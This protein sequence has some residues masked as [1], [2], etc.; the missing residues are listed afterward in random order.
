MRGR[1]GHGAEPHRA[2]GAWSGE[3]ARLFEG[4]ARGRSGRFRRGLRGDGRR[5]RA[6]RFPQL[7]LRLRFLSLLFLRLLFRL[8]LFLRLL[9]LYFLFFLRLPHSR[10]HRLRRLGVR[11]CLLRLGFLGFLGRDFRLFRLRLFCLRLALQPLR[12]SLRALRFLRDARAFLFRPNRNPRVPNR[13]R[14]PESSSRVWVAHPLPR[15]GDGFLH[16]IFLLPPQRVRPA[17]IRRA[18]HENLTHLLHAMAGPGVHVEAVHC[19][20]PQTGAVDVIQ[21]V[22]IREALL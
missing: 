1:D 17:V 22:I 15:R 16:R 10:H 13:R 12:L 8:R 18:H 5:V 2:L 4:S 9:F 19:G 11:L 20:W 3:R 21:L 14:L 7:F 6:N